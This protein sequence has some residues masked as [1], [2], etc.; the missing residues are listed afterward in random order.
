V[1]VECHLPVTEWPILT[2]IFKTRLDYKVRL[3]KFVRATQ[4]RLRSTTVSPIEKRWWVRKLTESQ[5]KA[6]SLPT[7]LNSQSELLDVRMT[8]IKSCWRLQSFNVSIYWRWVTYLPHLWK[9]IKKE[10]NPFV[11]MLDSADT[12]QNFICTEIQPYD[13]YSPFSPSSLVIYNFS[14][15]N[16][17]NGAL[18]ILEKSDHDNE[19]TSYCK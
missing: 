3:V 9:D 17:S 12:R 16:S 1:C 10:R 15:A 2:K 11:T 6:T 5:E 4:N 7:R 14:F 13:T 19:N 8:F 18:N